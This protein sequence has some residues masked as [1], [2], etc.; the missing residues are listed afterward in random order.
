MRRSGN[1]RMSSRVEVLAGMVKLYGEA[2]LHG[3]GCSLHCVL[4]QRG[5]SHAHRARADEGA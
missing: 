5:K 1:D 3:L 2:G 4:H